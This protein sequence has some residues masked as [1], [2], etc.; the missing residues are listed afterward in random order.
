[1]FNSRTTRIRIEWDGYVR[2]QLAWWVALSE[3][4]RDPR[5]EDNLYLSQKAR[6]AL[7]NARH[8]AN[9]LPR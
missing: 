4:A 8:P 5:R 2:A 7:E 3:L 6:K 1:M 9:P